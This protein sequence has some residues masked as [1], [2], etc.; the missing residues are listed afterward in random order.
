MS[1]K[2][3][4]PIAKAVYR[5]EDIVK[6]LAQERPETEELGRVRKPYL[7]YAG[8]VMRR[9]GDEEAWPTSG[10]SLRSRSCHHP[11]NPRRAHRPN[12][13]HRRVI[14]GISQDDRTAASLGATYPRAIRPLQ[15]AG[16]PLL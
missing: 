3:G 6:E 10:G 15:G 9:G 4:A 13:Y 2:N 5:A 16:K 12:P 1:E 11:T 14:N 8:L 7:G